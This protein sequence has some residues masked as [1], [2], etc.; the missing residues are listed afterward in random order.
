MDDQDLPIIQHLEATARGVVMSTF[1]DAE[2]YAAAGVLLSDDELAAVVAGINQPATGKLE[3]QSITFPALSAGNKVLLRGFLIQFRGK[4]VVTK[5][6][7]HSIQVETRATA[8][9][10]VEV[11]SE[12]LG[13]DE[14][15]K[16]LQNPMCHITGVVTG[17]QTMMVSTWAK[18][19]FA[20][21]RQVAAEAAT[22]FHCFCKLPHDKMESTLGFSGKQGVF[23]TPKEQGTSAASGRYRIIWLDTLD[24]DRATTWIRMCPEILGIVRGRT[25]LGL[26]TKASEYSMLRR[27]VE[28]GWSPRGINTDL[29]VTRKWILSPMP[30]QTDKHCVQQ[31]LNQFGWRAVPLRQTS[32]TSWMVGSSETDD[33]PHDLFQLQGQPVLITEHRHQQHGRQ[34]EAV[35]AASTAFEKQFGQQLATGNAQSALQPT[36]PQDGVS[37]QTQGPRSVFSDFKDDL[38]AKLHKR[39][40]KER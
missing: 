38:N 3:C 19:F 4:K 9:L 10:A 6:L 27:K 33:P 17:L 29:V 37:R 28:P 26:R 36:N 23:L 8:T 11:W 16:V 31:V 18:K 2:S 5:T 20:D 40:F 21:K 32:A 34:H 13:A 39:N 1:K 22:T 35:L 25:S 30:T 15:K 12:F 14:W 7:E 24:V